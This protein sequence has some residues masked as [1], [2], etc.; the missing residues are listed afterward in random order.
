[1]FEVEADI[2][3]IV[4]KDLSDFWAGKVRDIFN[5][6][7]KE[8][9]DELRRGSPI[10]ASGELARGWTYTPSR[11]SGNVSEFSVN[12][13]NTAPNAYFRIVGRGPGKFPPTAPVEAWVKKKLKGSP[14]DIRNR[15]FLIRRKIAEEGTERWK[16]GKNWAGLKRKGGFEPDSPIGRAKA[17]IQADLR[18]LKLQ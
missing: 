15:V 11:K 1:M 18:S 10:G 4:R 12:I 3:K 2:K 13:T 8:A 9:V 6:H 17:K 14:A 7:A 5:R 16:A